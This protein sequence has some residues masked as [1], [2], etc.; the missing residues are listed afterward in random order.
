MEGRL[1]ERASHGQASGGAIWSE[2]RLGCEPRSTTTHH[3]LPASI[4]ASLASILD[5]APIGGGAADAPG[6][7]IHTIHYWERGSDLAHDA[8]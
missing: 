7:Q 6:H 5:R 3:A 1:G 8:A 4:E 2:L